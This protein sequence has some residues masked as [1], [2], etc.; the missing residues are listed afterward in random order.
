MQCII[1]TL[2][3][4]SERLENTFQYLKRKKDNTLSEILERKE[5]F[6]LEEKE[7]GHTW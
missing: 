2:N 7:M 6:I 1:I 3:T 4:L 5:F